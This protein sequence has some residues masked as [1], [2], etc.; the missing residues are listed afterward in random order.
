[1]TMYQMYRKLLHGSICAI[2]IGCYLL[3]AGARAA[4]RCVMVEYFTN[5]HC[6][7]CTLTTAALDSLTEEYPDSQAV[8]IRC[9]GEATSPFFRLASG[10][11]VDYY[12]K[13][14]WVIPRSYF[15]GIIMI[16]GIDSAYQ[17]YK[18]AI[19]GWLAIPSPLEMSLSAVYDSLAGG[20]QIIAQVEAVD[21]VGGQD[22]RLR[23]GLIESGLVY[24]GKHYLEIL[25]DLFPDAEGVGFEIESGE[26]FHD[27]V[28]FDLDELWI[29]EDCS[30]IDTLEIACVAW[31][32]DD[33]SMEV[34]QSIQIPLELPPASPLAVTMLSAGPAGSNMHLSWTPVT[35]DV[36]CRPIS[37]D[38]YRIYRSS[39]LYY[40]PGAAV[41]LDSTAASSY[42]DSSCTC[43]KNLLENCFYYLV[44]RRSGKVSEPSGAVGE[45]D[46]YL[47]YGK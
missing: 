18:D 24:G 21:S 32:Q 2:L 15:D 14:P 6:Q 28:D 39:D 45:I 44:A 5:V 37:V 10:S 11:R 42:L 17:N 33:D 23:Y 31:V 30:E 43:V 22:L 29:P 19:D 13:W 3:A 20:G 7:P 46:H 26:V 36:Y 9:H 40:N 27:T 47:Y 35:L 4:D 12:Y 8:I 25:I 34:L 41:L 1:M 38:D 16:Q